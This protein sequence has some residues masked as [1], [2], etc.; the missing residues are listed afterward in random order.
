LIFQADAGIQA[1]IVYETV[2][3]LDN[4]IFVVGENETAVAAC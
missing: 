3:G 4:R 2:G 1:G